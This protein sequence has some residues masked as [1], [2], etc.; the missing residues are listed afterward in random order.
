MISL[1]IAKFRLRISK[2]VVRVFAWLLLIAVI[3]G[4]L[5]TVGVTV[6]P[7]DDDGELMVLVPSLWATERYREQVRRWIGELTE[8]DRR[9]TALLDQDVDAANSTE[10]YHQGQEMQ[11]VGEMAFSVEQRITFADSPVAMVGLREQ[12]KITAE[13]YLE[14]AVL[15]SRWLNAPS[16]TG[17]R[18]ALESLERARSQRETLENSR[19][20]KSYPL[21][22]R[23]EPNHSWHVYRG[24][25]PR[26]AHPRRSVSRKAEM[27]WKNGVKTGGRCAKL[28]GATLVNW[29][30]MR[31]TDRCYAGGLARD[32]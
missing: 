20:L 22:G 29:R 32:A 19:W 11:V 6:T 16:E 12:A 21:T 18:E 3:V 10:L 24:T 13:A 7:R 31:K 14:S 26:V 4:G 5:H 28:T 23:Y 2:R 30:E 25:L 27:T 15:T 8:I 9:L 17:Q 1:R